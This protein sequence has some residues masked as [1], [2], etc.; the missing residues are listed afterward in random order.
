MVQKKRLFMEV[1]IRKLREDGI[2]RKFR[3]LLII[4]HEVIDMIT[5]KKVYEVPDILDD[6]AGFSGLFSTPVG[7]WCTDNFDCENMSIKDAQSNSVCL[8]GNIFDESIKDC[9]I[10]TFL[11]AINYGLEKDKLV[12]IEYEELVAE[13]KKIE[14]IVYE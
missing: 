12:R 13:C 3:I 1:K 11:D 9:L 14:M 5:R 6:Y 10:F 7:I 2:I 8:S 4:G